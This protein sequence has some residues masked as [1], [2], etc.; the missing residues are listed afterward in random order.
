MDC[1]PQFHQTQ[2]A[3]EKC[4]QD[5]LHCLKYVI[6]ARVDFFLTVMEEKLTAVGINSFEVLQGDGA[7]KNHEYSGAKRPY[8]AF[9]S[10]ALHPSTM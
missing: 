3:W 5:T 9:I 4:S 2:V 7:W 1:P 6:I 8:F 10:Y